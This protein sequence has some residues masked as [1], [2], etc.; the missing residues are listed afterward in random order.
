MANFVAKLH[1][2]AEFCNFEVSLEAILW[3]QIVRGINDSAIQGRLWQKL[4]V[5]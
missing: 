5:T 1:V 4:P 3:D 2:L